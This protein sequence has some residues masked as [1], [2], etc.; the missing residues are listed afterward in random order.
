MLNLNRVEIYT[1]I[2][3][4]LDMIVFTY[5][6]KICINFVHIKHFNI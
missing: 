1:K 4:I 5:K 6:E 3:G 2:I